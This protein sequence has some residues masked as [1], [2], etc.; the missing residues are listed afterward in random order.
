MGTLIVGLLIIGA[1]A[2][3]IRSMARDKKRKIDALRRRLRTLRRMPLKTWLSRRQKGKGPNGVSIRCWAGPWQ[4]GNGIK[5][6]AE[7]SS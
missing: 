3:A 1:V 5:G 2:L 4:R 7:P 6:F